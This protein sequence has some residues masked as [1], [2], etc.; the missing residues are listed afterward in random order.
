[1][2]NVDF[3]PVRRTA[4]AYTQTGVT[5]TQTLTHTQAEYRRALQN[6]NPFTVAKGAHKN[7]FVMILT[8]RAVY[9]SRTAD[10]MPRTKIRAAVAGE[11]A[12]AN[13]DITK[14][15]FRLLQKLIV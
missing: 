14:P 11:A 5:N 7:I 1:M 8:M 10:Q 4:A 9:D 15:L 2:R 3:S 12:L 13:A 6:F